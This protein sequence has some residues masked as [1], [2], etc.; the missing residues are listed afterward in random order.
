MGQMFAPARWNEYFVFGQIL[1]NSSLQTISDVLDG[2]S[3]DVAIGNNLINYGRVLI[4]LSGGYYWHMLE[5][6]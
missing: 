1:T 6:C 4:D 3:V 5:K 2:D